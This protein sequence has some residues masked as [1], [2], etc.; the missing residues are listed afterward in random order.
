MPLKQ[1]ASI[2]IED[3][4]T[5]RV[6][7]YDSSLVKEIEKAITAADLGVG[8]GSDETGVRVTFPELTA[9]R[10]QEFVKLAKQKLEDAR[11]TV[12]KAR[13]EVWSDVQEKEREGELTE[14]DKYMLKDELQKRVDA[15]QAALE[16]LFE[17][18][19]SEIT[20]K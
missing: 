12:R 5:L 18:K 13:E 7:A 2:A 3:P 14:D 19:E 1:A 17:Q 4:R 20:T 8:T 16:S 9:E 11:T 6:A 15:V 10:R